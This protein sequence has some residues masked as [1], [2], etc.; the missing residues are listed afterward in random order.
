MVGAC[1]ALLVVAPGYLRYEPRNSGEHI[2]PILGTLAVLSAS[3][4]GFGL[5]RSV[6]VLVKATRLSG[7]LKARARKLRMPGELEAYELPEQSRVSTVVGVVRPTMFFSTA[8]L[9]ALNEA[10]LDSVLR[11]EKAHVRSG[12]NSTALALDFAS[13]LTLNPVF[14]RTVRA[15][16]VE[17]AEI[18]ADL[19]AVHNKEQA[20]DLL[21]ALVKV[22]KLRGNA[23]VGALG[24]SFVPKATKSHL[25]RRIESLQALAD[26]R[27]VQ[28]GVLSP[29]FKSGMVA[30]AVALLVGAHSMAGQAHAT[31]ELLMK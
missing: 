19:D 10:E 2:G 13:R 21:S 3:M 5:W 17:A 23:A 4:I 24:C 28:S 30:L 31:L 8:V 22:S 9:K 15:H 1:T 14:A 16:W 18:A 27:E 26:G 29:A 12:D 25:R 7:E 11:H 6:T 20:L